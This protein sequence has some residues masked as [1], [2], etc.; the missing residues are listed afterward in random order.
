M[1]GSDMRFH[2][3]ARTRRALLH[4]SAAAAALAL[5]NAVRAA[6]PP[7]AARRSG[8]VLVVGD[9]LSAEY[10]L[11][12][13]SGWVALL[14]QRLAQRQIAVPV[15]NASISGE[16]SSGGLSRL[17]ALLEQHHPGVLIIE[18]GGNDA[19]RGLP[20]SMTQANLASMARMGRE[21][22]AQVV[23]VGMQ[24]PPNYGK[25][26][27][28]EFASMFQHVAKEQHARLVPFLL[29]GVADSSDGQS[30]FQADR[31]HPTMQAQPRML[32]NVWPVLEPLL[33]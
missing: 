14:I 33:H 18:L 23:I 27:A 9:S 22:D 30:L 7:K 10:G 19:L 31:I 5:A 3:F 1:I 2:G 26:Y 12:R 4:C 15:V 8:P 29:A 28:Q 16:T 20:M 17:P 21:A 6:P 11:E 13:G 25:R 32:D 24:V